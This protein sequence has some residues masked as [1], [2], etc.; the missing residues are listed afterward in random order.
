LRFLVAAGVVRTAILAIANTI[1]IAIAIRAIGYAIT[2]TIS[3]IGAPALGRFNRDAT[4]QQ[5]ANGDQ[6]Y[7]KLFHVFSWMK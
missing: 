7:G 6:H 5:G 3:V 2:V 1:T 4:G